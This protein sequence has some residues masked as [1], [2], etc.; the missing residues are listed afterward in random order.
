MSTEERLSYVEAGLTN[1]QV[2]LNLLS[3]IAER[4]L[5]LL[6]RLD[7]NMEEVRRDTKMTQRLWVRLAQRH[8]WIEDDDWAGPGE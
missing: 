6:E 7:A 3:S 8:G 2:Q 5:E 4:Q 1:H